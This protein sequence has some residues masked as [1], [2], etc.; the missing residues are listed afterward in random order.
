MDLAYTAAGRIGGYFEARLQP[1]D[2]A[3][4]SLMIEEAGGRV[5]RPDGTPLRILEPNPVIAGNRLTYDA[6]LAEGL[7]EGL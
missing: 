7:Q 1:W 2:F 6:F 5:S 3:A 4:S